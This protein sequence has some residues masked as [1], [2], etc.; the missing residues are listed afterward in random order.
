MAVWK[1]T[2]PLTDEDIEK[3]RIGDQVYITGT[4]YTGRDAAHKKLVELIEANKPLPFDVKGQIIYYV[5]PTPARPGKPVGS[6]GPTTS[7]R[8]DSYAPY[9]YAL[10]IKATI[11]KGARSEEVKEALK[12]YKA[13]YLGA[14]GGA[15]ALISKRIIKS[16]IVAY[17]EL[18]PE[19]IRKMEVKDFPVI[20]INDMYGGDLFLEGKKKYHV[21]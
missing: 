7:Y 9:L 13:V 18:G 8:M 6:A 4:I 14:V 20:V 21:E 11:G 5:G 19:A 10:G 12:K 16:E 15:G 2:T 1:L 17:P 3:L